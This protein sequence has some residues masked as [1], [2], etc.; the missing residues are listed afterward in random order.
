MAR[1]KKQTRRRRDNR[2]NA[3]NALE[4]LLFA[5]ILTEAAF[6]TDAWNF[7][8]AGTSLN[9]GTKW[10]GQGATVV[11]LKE[12]VTWPTSAHS[13]G[14]YSGS[15]RGDIIMGNLSKNWL[16]AGFKSL[17]LGIGFKAGKKILSKPRRI[18]N[19]NLKMLSIPVRV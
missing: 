16:D 15:S 12:L 13:P 10:T 4:G 7:L 18:V 1:R 2:F 14:A 19:K 9:P 11:S 3:T 8:T 5:N 6:K 17:M